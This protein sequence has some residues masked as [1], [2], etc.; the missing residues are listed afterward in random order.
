MRAVMPE[1]VGEPLLS[2]D[3]FGFT[4]RIGRATKH[5]WKIPK[6][7]FIDP[8]IAYRFRSSTFISKEHLCFSIAEWGSP[9]FSQAPPPAGED[10]LKESV[11]IISYYDTFVKFGSMK[12]F[13]IGKDED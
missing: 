4:F 10:T 6:D 13:F 11:S 12:P 9:T 5:L 3:G 2:P 1:P 7:V 8:V